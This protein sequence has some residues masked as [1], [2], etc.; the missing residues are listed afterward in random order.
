MCGFSKI[1][2]ATVFVNLEAGMTVEEVM[3]EFDVTQE[4]MNAV[5]EF[6]ASSLAAPVVPVHSLTPADAHPL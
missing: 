2:V 1:P 6:V 5:L 4:Q 3:E